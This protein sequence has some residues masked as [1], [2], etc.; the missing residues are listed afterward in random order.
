MI[1]DVI[2]AMRVRVRLAATVAVAAAYT[3]SHAPHARAAGPSPL[4]EFYGIYARSNG[5]LLDLRDAAE[6]AKHA[7]SGRATFLVYDK[8]VLLASDG[9]ELEP[10]VFVHDRIEAAERETL[11]RFVAREDRDAIRLRSRPVPDKKEMIELVPVK[12]LPKGLYILARDSES[13]TIFSVGARLKKEGIRVDA[14]VS[15]KVEYVPVGSCSVTP[16]PSAMDRLLAHAADA[17]ADENAAAET[18]P[19]SETIVSGTGIRKAVIESRLE[20]ARPDLIACFDAGSGSTKTARDEVVLHFIIRADGK[21]LTANPRNA[22]DRVGTCIAQTVMKLSFPASSDGQGVIVDFPVRRRRVLSLGTDI[23]RVEATAETSAASDVAEVTGPLDPAIIQAVIR[24][25]LPQITYCYERELPGHPE[26][27]GKIVVH[28]VIEKDGRV[29][30]ASMKST[31]MH[32]A[33]VEGCIVDRFKMI[34]FPEPKDRQSVTV[35]YPF[36]FKPRTP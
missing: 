23:N 1:L 16:A 19:K 20:D 8:S 13:L 9:Y 28:F 14:C 27:G 5:T 7:V 36:T 6:I 18:E 15:E 26:L 24:R 21:V 35:N 29:S 4:P 2:R 22:D 12:P 11:D 31:T 30:A 17:E 32:D 33:N 25:H 10:A 34:R 3:L